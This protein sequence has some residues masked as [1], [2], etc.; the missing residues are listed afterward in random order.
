MTQNGPN[1]GRCYWACAE[2]NP[3]C[4]KLFLWSDG[5]PNLTFDTS[6][7]ASP[8][9]SA[10]APVSTGSKGACADPGV[11]S[12]LDRMRKRS[13]EVAHGADMS[14]AGIGG[15]DL[16]RAMLERTP[17]RVVSGSVPKTAAESTLIKAGEEPVASGS[18]PSSSARQPA[19]DSEGGA[20]NPEEEK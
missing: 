3:N 2:R 13:A 15:R 11:G 1:R 5:G 14:A 20:S 17:P 18:V 9:S 6:S 19:C 12:M 10:L 7:T 8:A 4:K 16:K